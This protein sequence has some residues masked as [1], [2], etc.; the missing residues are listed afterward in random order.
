MGCQHALLLAPSCFVRCLRDITS[1][2]LMRVYV[3]TVKNLL[4]IRSIHVKFNYYVACSYVCKITPFYFCN[5][6]IEAR[7][8]K[9]YFNK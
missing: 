7:E 8:R 1:K 9:C 6:L 5:H 2:I 4:Y 3:I